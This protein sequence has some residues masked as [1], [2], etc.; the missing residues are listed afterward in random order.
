MTDTKITLSPGDSV[1]VT[2]VSGPVPPIP[3]T[4]P[5]GSVFI[6]HIEADGTRHS[7]TGVTPATTFIYCT[8]TVPTGVNGKQMQISTYNTTGPAIWRK[9]NLARQP[10]DFTALPNGSDQ[11]GTPSLHMAIGTPQVGCVTVQAGEVWVLNIRDQ[12][13][14]GANSCSLGQDCNPTV[15]L[16]PPS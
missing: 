5:P 4:P 16:F 10:G 8:F 6:G 9:V 7:A 12:S 11:G 14:T 1:L 13:F 15:A 3:P 2:A